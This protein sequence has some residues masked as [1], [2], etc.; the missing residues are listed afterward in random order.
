MPRSR[1]NYTISRI[2]KPGTRKRPRSI[3]FSTEYQPSRKKQVPDCENINTDENQSSVGD[4]EYKRLKL[5]TTNL[6]RVEKKQPVLPYKLR[7][8]NDLQKEEASK[9]QNVSSDHEYG[10]VK[11]SSISELMNNFWMNHAKLAE[12]LNCK[13]P[14]IE[15]VK[16]QHMGL[17]ITAILRCTK[18]MVSSEPIEL[19]DKTTRSGKRGPAAGS[20]NTAL[21]LACLK[22]KMGMKDI[23]FFLSTLSIQPPSSNLL[24]RNLNKMSDMVVKIN[25]QSMI[26]NQQIVKEINQLSRKNDEYVSV[27]TDSSYNNRLQLGFEA[28]TQSFSPMVENVTTKKLTLSLQYVNRLCSKKHKNENH[29]DCAKNYPDNKSMASSEGYLVEKNIN[30]INSQGIL[31]VG[32][33]TSDACNQINRVCQSRS[34]KS[35]RHFTCYVH[36]MRNFQKHIHYMQVSTSSNTYNLEKNQYMKQLALAFRKRIQ[37]EIGRINNRCKRETE[38]VKSASLCIRN[39]ID[40]FVNNHSMCHILST[41]CQAHRESFKPTFLPCGKYLELS[42]C[43]LNKIT[44]I[45]EKDFSHDNLHQ[46]YGLKTTNK[47]ESMHNRLMTYITKRVTWSR[48]FSAMC[49]SAVHSDT[50]G[51]GQSTLLIAKQAGIPYC[52]NGPMRNHMMHIDNINNYCKARQQTEKYKQDRYFGKLRRHNRKLLQNSMYMLPASSTE[53]HNFAIK[54]I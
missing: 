49:H 14:N 22:T 26:T 48:N 41:V 43:D 24:Q 1:S 11:L 30:N 28:A 36:K 25:E 32:A 31:K 16:K 52:D 42:R 38:F 37:K 23:Q 53:T 40:C 39:V 27:E 34:G 2:C 3:Q 13:I 10:I 12:R 21:P 44:A 7:P 35:V 33:I 4:L 8:L 46:L 6:V 9:R 47:S 51:T 20:L 18:C 5:S 54:P 17:C 19:Y 29:N 45:L 50:F 15:F